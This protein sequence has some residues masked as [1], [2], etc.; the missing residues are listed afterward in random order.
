MAEER[1]SVIAVGAH[2]DD[3]EFG[4]GG[5]IALHADAG[6]LITFVYASDGE[7]GGDPKAR[8]R[9][10]RES[11]K[12]LGAQR[13]EF[14][15]FPD[16]S[17][18]D[19]IGIVSRIEDILNKVGA[20][21]VYTHTSSERHQDHRHVSQAATSAARN[22]AVLMYFETPSSSNLFRPQCYVDITKT[23]DRKIEAVKTHLSQSSK[24]GVGPDV[25]KGQAKFMGFDP[26]FQYAECFEISHIHGL[27]WPQRFG[28]SVRRQ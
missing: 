28:K 20:E 8:V 25:V 14:L 15:G 18:G 2:P 17:I 11:A 26:Q 3:I 27:V 7:C 13:T 12:I 24:K 1:Y 5:T 10:A 9:E 23:L 4:C 16:G 21:I 19:S 6:D 22:C